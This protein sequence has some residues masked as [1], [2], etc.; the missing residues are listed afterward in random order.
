MPEGTAGAAGRVTG[1]RVRTGADLLDAVGA[2]CA[3][4]SVCAAQGCGRV[5]V[6][7]VRARHPHSP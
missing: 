3:V 5:S 6:E 1:R 2:G 7:E 4:F